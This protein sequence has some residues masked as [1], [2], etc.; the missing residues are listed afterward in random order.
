MKISKNWLNYLVPNFDYSRSCYVM[1]T[2][3]R[4]LFESTQHHIIL[5]NITLLVDCL[6]F[7]GRRRDIT[8]LMGDK[9][10]HTSSH[11][12]PSNTNSHA[13]IRHRRRFG[14][15]QQSISSSGA[16]DSGFVFHRRSIGGWSYLAA[17]IVNNLKICTLKAFVLISLLTRKIS[18]SYRLFAATM[19]STDSYPLLFCM[20]FRSTW[21]YPTLVRLMFD[22]SNSY[23][24]TLEVKIG[25]SK[26]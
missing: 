22:V 1:H 10:L 12:P 2:F 24:P 5:F 21:N 14:I 6:L 23:L 20:Y 26:M 8:S 3:R 25:M 9:E 16:L 13:D 17:F 19:G 7:I 15:K 4:S 18:A 11:L